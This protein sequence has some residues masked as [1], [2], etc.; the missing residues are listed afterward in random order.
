MFLQKWCVLSAYR[1]RFFFT[2]APCPTQTKKHQPPS[3]ELDR[4]DPC[5]RPRAS[6]SHIYHN[7]CYGF[8]V[9]HVATMNLCQEMLRHTVQGLSAF[10]TLSASFVNGGFEE[11]LN[12]IGCVN[13]LT[14]FSL[15]FIYMLK[16]LYTM[17]WMTVHQ[18]ISFCTIVHLWEDKVPFLLT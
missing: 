16:Q 9:P 7:V 12:L 8:M 1:Y 18:T 14:K 13:I 5:W 2:P 15:C 17:F 11:T 3:P 10:F 6:D 4:V